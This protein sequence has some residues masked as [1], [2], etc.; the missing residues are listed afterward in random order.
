MD[1]PE[2]QSGWVESLDPLGPFG[3]KGV[4]EGTQLPVVP[5][6]ANAIHDALGVRAKELPLWPWE[7]EKLGRF[8]LS[9]GES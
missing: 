4:G 2:I 5:A 7:G 3:A 1:A 9:P 8:R 6:I